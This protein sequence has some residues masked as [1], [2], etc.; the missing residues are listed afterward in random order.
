[1]K[2]H[3]DIE[4][5]TEAWLAIK[6]GKVGASCFADILAKGQGKT[7][8]AYMRRVVAERLLGQPIETYRNAHMDRGI[9]Q[10]PLARLAYEAATD[11]ELR[12]VA[13]IE[14]DSLAA[15]CS[16][17]SLIV[18]KDRGLE[19]K[20][21]IPTVQ[22]ET[23]YGG[24]MPPEHRA[25]VQGSMWITGYSEWDFLSYSPTMPKHLRAFIVTVERD[26]A[27]ID[28]LEREV[29]RFLADVD[30]M[31]DALRPGGPDLE[32]KLRASL[33]VAA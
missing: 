9:E 13:F 24:V 31:I 16:P 26:Q 22:V 27:F 7:R 10:E 29:R 32:G 1:M 4:Q 15:G 6:A 20:C 18:W 19:I 14:H 3:D 5:G 21:V 28:E 11:H 2:V 17:D 8:A 30:R 33:K 12:R 25:Q 23:V